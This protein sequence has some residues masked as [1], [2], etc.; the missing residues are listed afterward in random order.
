VRETRPIYSLP[1]GNNPLHMFGYNMPT[2]E[3]LGTDGPLP[4]A[5][6]L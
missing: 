5:P 3:N 1:K 4:V 6:H 2:L